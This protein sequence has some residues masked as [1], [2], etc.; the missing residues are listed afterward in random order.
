MTQADS[1]VAHDDFSNAREQSAAIIGESACPGDIT[2]PMETDYTVIKIEASDNEISTNEIPG[3]FT[4]TKNDG[5]PEVMDSIPKGMVGLDD[6]EQEKFSS[7]GGTSVELDRT[8]TELAQSL[9]T[10]RSEELSP[11]GVITDANSLNSSTATSVGLASQLVLPKIAAPVICLVDEQKD[12]LQQLAFVRIVDAYK[13]VAV[14]GGS[15]VR[16]SVLAHAG[17]EV[18]TWTYMTRYILLN[19]SLIAC[20]CLMQF[21]SELDPWKLLKTHVLSDYVN[22]EVNE[23]LSFL[24]VLAVA[25]IFVFCILLVELS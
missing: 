23:Y 1:N 24:W 16:F 25:Q 3:L 17:M 14:A 15:Q 21:P 22:H 18:N 20:Y 7:F 19:Q 9:S 8:P 10:D 4:A 5:I 13:H 2:S 12:Q 11:K 6:A